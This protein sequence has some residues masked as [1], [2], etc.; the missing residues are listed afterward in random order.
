M[1]MKDKEITKV[2]V[3]FYIQVFTFQLFFLLFFK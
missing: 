1:A 3:S 2:A